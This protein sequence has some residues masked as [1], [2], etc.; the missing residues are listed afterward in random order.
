MISL[1][2]NYLFV[3]NTSGAGVYIRTLFLPLSMRN[4]KGSS[5]FPKRSMPKIIIVILLALCVL[6]SLSGS[7]EQM[8]ERPPRV[9]THQEIC[10]EGWMCRSTETLAAIQQATA[11]GERP[12]RVASYNVHKCTGMDARRDVDRIAEAIRSLDADIV[13]LQEVLSEPGD[14]PAAQVRSIAQKTGMYAAVAAPTKRKK[15]GLYGNA[16]LSRFPMEQVRLHDISVASFEPRGVIDADIRVGGRLVR[17]IATHFGLRPSEGNLQAERLLRILKGMPPSPL[18]VMGD[19]NS[20]LPGSRSLRLLK[21]HL[22]NPVSMASYP[23]AFALL[24]LDKIWA[25]DARHPVSGRVYSSPV[26]RMASDHLPLV[27]SVY[28]PG[29]SAGAAS[30][31]SPLQQPGLIAPASF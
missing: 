18:I 6:Y 14:V 29:L 4:S 20:W 2:L 16:L 30:P 8:P 13:S 21:E 31:A 19:M 28:L 23:A 26:T 3:V 22:G 25:P 15:D 12:L 9:L 27:A 11:R 7:R 24:A 17:V 10:S 1:H 5:L